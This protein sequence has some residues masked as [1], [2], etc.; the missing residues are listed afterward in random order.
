MFNT[1]IEEI[2]SR[3]DIIDVIGNY[4]RLQKAGRNYKAICPFHN[5]KTPS[6]MVSPE[7]QIWHCFGCN[8]GGDVFGFVMKMDGLEFGDTLRLLA[9][10]AGVILKRQDAKLGTQRQKFYEICE[11]ATKFFEK[12]LWAGKIGEEIQKYLKERGLLE[13][14]IKEW[15]LGY[16]PNLW[17]SLEEFLLNKGH[18]YEEILNAGLIIKN[19]NQDTRH[20]TQDIRYYD[21]F[22]DRIMFPIS[23]INGQVVGFS[24]R[25]NP[26]S[27]NKESA[28]YINSPQTFIYDK[29][30]I[31][32]GLDKAKIEIRKQNSCIIVEGNMDAVMSY[33]TGT[34]N[35]VASSGTALTDHQLKIIKRYT[36]NLTIAFDSDL[37]GDTATKKGIDLAL[38]NDFNVK[39]IKL[40]EKDPADLIKTNQKEWGEAVKNAKEIIEF[41]FNNAFIKLDKLSNFGAK[42]KKQ[43]VQILL[44]I[45]KK[46]KNKIEQAHW[47]QELSK[48]IAIDEKI[49]W[50][51]IKEIK[52]ME[53]LTPLSLTTAE[54]KSASCNER[55]EPKNQIE[56]LEMRLVGLLLAWPQKFDLEKIETSFF[57][58]HKF[59]QIIK[60]LKQNQEIKAEL[61]DLKNSLLFQ[62]ESQPIGEKN[63]AQE[64]EFC[65]NELKKR[66]TKKK[67]E[68]I[69]QQIRQAEQKK[70]NQT[71]NN[72]LEK[73]KTLSKE[74]V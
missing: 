8:E 13:K 38:Q 16:A 11:L 28:R 71:V 3:L 67:L 17:H 5:E 22:R 33:Q 15:R 68:E 47:L 57:T 26:F 42:D 74:L 64:I 44:P 60:A 18:K 63:I 37:A 6:F 10:K 14:T 58:N 21:R 39:I 29:G 35:T 36:D 48:K 61:A 40:T 30:R 24:G 7:R 73:F 32:Y 19:E 69:G 65:F 23:D 54:I 53:N 34:K 1:Q 55:L 25:I 27:E 62:I 2:K 66:I 70:D 51:Q 72:L 49:L 20:K 41:Y 59:I 4:I 56:S 12:Q 52:P 9:K 45:I 46:I 50:E 31:L 43:I